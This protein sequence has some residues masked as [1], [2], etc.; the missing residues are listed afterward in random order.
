VA[1]ETSQRSAFITSV[2]ALTASHHRLS[3]RHSSSSIS[4][5]KQ[6]GVIAILYLSDF[7]L[8]NVSGDS[9]C[10]INICVSWKF[11]VARTQVLLADIAIL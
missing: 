11:L 2:L 6:P 9:V 1:P 10:E 8:V 4:N 3:D 7:V 5:S